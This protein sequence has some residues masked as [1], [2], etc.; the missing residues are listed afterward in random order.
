MVGAAMEGAAYWLIPQGLL[1]LL[2]YSV[3][4]HQPRDHQPRDAAAYSLGP[5]AVITN[6]EKSTIG[7]PAGH[8]GG[9]VFSVE[10][11]SSQMTLSCVRLR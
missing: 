1:S 10:V 7:L 2:S 9:G 11:F 3:W 6:P 5:P 4:D 8:S